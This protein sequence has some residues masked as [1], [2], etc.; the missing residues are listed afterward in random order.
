MSSGD[1]LSKED[2]LCL[3]ELIYQSLFCKE[4]TDLSKVIDKLKCLIPFDFALCGFATTDGKG[5][6]RSHEIINITYPSEWLNLY[7]TKKY[8]QIDPIVGENFNKFKL[9][10]WTDT[11]RKNIPPKDFLFNAEDFGLKRGYTYGARNLK[12]TEGS[13]F[14][15]S[16]PSLE[17][18]NRT[19]TILTHLIPHIHQALTRILGNHPIKNKINLSAR[20]K[21]V[22]N[23]LKLGK[24]TWDISKIIGISERTVNFHSDIII[25]KLDVVNRTQAVAV[26]IGQGLIDIE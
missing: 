24:S 2:A 19:E 10:Y 16:S 20:Q 4:K 18:H 22:L 11:Y 9:Q 26:A 13:I 17:R 21:E 5:R 3:L 6:I 12:G 1:L 7:V 23:W 14:S 8:Y 25:Q 15:V